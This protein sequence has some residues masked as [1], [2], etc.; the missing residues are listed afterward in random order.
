MSTGIT[1]KSVVLPK[2]RNLA[3]LRRNDKTRSCSR[4][5]LNQFQKNT[6][7]TDTFDLQSNANISGPLHPGHAEPGFGRL[8]DEEEDM[9]EEDN[10]DDDDDGD[11]LSSSPSIPDDVSLSYFTYILPANIFSGY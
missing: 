2:P 1:V 9:Y 5:Y 6:N 7:S 8:G 10:E 4:R 3:Y 11:A